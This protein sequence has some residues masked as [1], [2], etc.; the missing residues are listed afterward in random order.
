MGD[1]S[2]CLGTFGE[3]APQ[4]GLRLVPG[5]GA[6]TF[7]KKGTFLAELS[8]A[9]PVELLLPKLT[10]LLGVPCNAV[11][12]MHEGRTLDTEKSLTENEI[13]IPGARARR[14]GEKV[15]LCF[16]T[17][18]DVM[19][20]VEEENKKQKEAEEEEQKRQLRLQLEQQ[21]REKKAREEIE[22]EEERHKKANRANELFEEQIA[23][24]VGVNREQ[25]EL[26]L[27]NP[28]P[29]VKKPRHF[30]QRLVPEQERALMQLLSASGGGGGGTVWA[31]EVHHQELR[32]R[33]ERAKQGLQADAA[34]IKRMES[35][36]TNSLLKQTDLGFLGPF[37]PSVNEFCLWH[38]TARLEGAGGICANGFD[39][40]YVGSAVGT[41]WGHG[42]YFADSASTS[43]GYTGGGVRVTEV[44]SRSLGQ[45]EGVLGRNSS[46]IDVRCLFTIKS[47]SLRLFFIVAGLESK[48]T[49]PCCRSG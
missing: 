5:D 33:Y 18:F 40:A 47:S 15:L 8:K 39:I 34:N 11:T 19:Q 43:M 48:S 10:E 32:E 16:D 49:T 26:I 44:H 28:D 23:T 31:Y 13:T 21:M 12:L 2:V 7:A 41:A 38:G 3:A 45:K 17:K 22:R 46:P 1:E 37:D 27:R 25:Y 20:G 9:S 42:F 14:E 4:I 6:S 24:Q 29:D 36:T 30:L 35:S